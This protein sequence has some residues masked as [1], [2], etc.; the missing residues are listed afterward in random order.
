MALPGLS[1]IPLSDG[2]PPIRPAAHRSYFPDKSTRTISLSFRAK[3][4]F[5]A[6]AGC[7]QIVIRVPTFRVGSTSFARLSSL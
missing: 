7:D 6:N 5:I 3:T 2:V 1:R 4:L